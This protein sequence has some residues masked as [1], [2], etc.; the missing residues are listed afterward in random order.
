MNPKSTLKGRGAQLNVP[1]RFLELSHEQR[2]DF[3]EF[4][5]KEGEQPD[6]NKTLYLPVFPKTIVN[7]VTSPD[8]G[9][10]LSLIHI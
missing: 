3:L 7:K 6:K 9:M 1:N 4:C 5:H 2:D 10:M 8:V